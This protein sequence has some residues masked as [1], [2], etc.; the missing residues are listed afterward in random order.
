[1]NLVILA[2]SGDIPIIVTIVIVVAILVGWT[3]YRYIA[4]SR[5]AELLNI[6]MSI[7]DVRK[8]FPYIHLYKDRSGTIC[9][10]TASPMWLYKV[11]LEFDTTGKLIRIKKDR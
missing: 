10:R 2:D 5:T 4:F 11:H 1:M 8:L 9:G 3:I 6:E 7:D